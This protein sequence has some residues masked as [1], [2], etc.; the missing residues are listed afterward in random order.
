MKNGNNDL[1]TDGDCNDNSTFIGLQLKKLMDLLMT[2]VHKL[3]NSFRNRWILHD[4]SMLVYSNK[5]DGCLMTKV[6]I[7]WS[8]V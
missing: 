4:N 3:V 7:N 6:Y 2:M 5:T 1:K 8:T